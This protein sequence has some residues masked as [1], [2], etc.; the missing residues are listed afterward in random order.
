[1]PRLEEGEREKERG[2]ARERLRRSKQSRISGLE[3]KF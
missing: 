2:T 1:M 3:P